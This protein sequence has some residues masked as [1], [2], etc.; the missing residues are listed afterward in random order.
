MPINYLAVFY[1]DKMF[2]KYLCNDINV[3]KSIFKKCWYGD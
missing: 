3:I 2:K 1:I